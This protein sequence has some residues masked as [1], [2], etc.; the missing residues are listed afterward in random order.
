MKPPIPNRLKFLPTILCLS[1]LAHNADAAI[2]WWDP[3]GTTSV[4]GNGTWDTTTPLWAPTTTTPAGAQAPSANL[5]V[6]NPANAA[7]FCAGPAASTQQGVFTINVESAITFAGLFNGSQ[8][9]GPCDVTITS[10]TGNG[11]LNLASGAQAFS[12]LNSSLGFTRINVPITGAGQIVLESSGQTFLNATNT[13]TGGT[14]LGFSSARWSGIVNFN[15]PYAFGPGPITMVANSGGA[16]VVSG[17]NPITITNSFTTQ[18]T[19]LNLVGNSAGLTFSGNWSLGSSTPN[20]GS[21][22]TGNTVV[23]AGVISGTGGINKSLNNGSAL[24]LSG[25]NTYSGKT[26]ISQGPLKVSSINSVSGGSPS[27]NLGA[28]T[29]AANGTIGIGSGTTAGTLI[30][31][32]V[33]ETTDRIINLGGTTGGATIQN[34]GTGALTFTSDFTAT[35]AGVKTLT[36][37]GSNT[38]NNTIAGKIVNSSA[39]TGVVKA[40]NGTW[41]LN[42]T[43]TYTGGTTIS[44]GT[45]VIGSTGAIVGN[46]TNNAGVL[47]LD[48]RTALTN[49]AALS[50]PSSLPSGAINLNFTGNQVINAIYIDGVLAAP[51][52]WGSPTSGAQNTSPVFTGTGI[53]NVLGAPV[54]VQQPQSIACFEGA[55]NESFTVQVSG[56]P[57][58]TYQWKHQGT[59]IPGAN[60]STYIIPVATMSDAGTYTCAIT[61]NYGGTVSLGAT[62]TVLATNSYVNAILA[63]GPISYWRLGETNGTI[64]HDGVGGN[65]GNY[66]NVALNQPG[67]SQT[68]ADGSVGVPASA[69]QGFVQITNSSPFNFPGVR[70][71]ALESWVN[72]TNVTGVQRI[73]STFA[74]AS[75]RGYA[76][77]INGG[78]VLRFTTSAVQD[79]DQ[80]L[81]TALVPGLWYHLVV[82]SDQSFY[83]FYVNGHEVGT[84]ITITGGGNQGVSQ[85]M[86]FGCNPASYATNFSN[87]YEQL[88][89]RIDEVAIYDFLTA[90]QVLAHYNARYGTLAPPVV[91]APV[92]TPATNYESLSTT[93]QAVAGGQALSYQ[94]FK[95]TTALPGQT[96]D[97]LTI[98]PLHLSDSGAYNVQVSNPVGTNTSTDVTITVLPIPTSASV[99]NLTNG[100][101]LHLPFDSDYADI[102]GHSNNGTNVGATTFVSP[103]A[104]G[105]KAL[106]Y[107]TDTGAGTTNYVTLGVRSDLKFSTN[108]DFTVAFWVRQPAGSTYTNLPFFTDAVGSTSHGGFAFAP[109][110]GTGGGGWMYTIGTVTSPNAATSFPDANL[111]N[112]GNW[113]HL[114]HVASRTA[115]CTTYLDGIQVDSQAITIAGNTD[116]TNPATIGQDPTGAYPVTADADIDD[117]AVWRRALT[118][119]EVSGIY[120]A[121]ATNSVSFAPA[122]ISAPVP[123]ALQLQQN[124]GQWQIIW[125]G[126]GGVLQASG[127]VSGTY[128]NVPSASSPYTI[129]TSSSP[130]M[131]YRLKY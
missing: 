36:L 39:A 15:N 2:Q 69:G 37:Q 14:S 1:I 81:A 47:E 66:I 102:S 34:D 7:G 100:L 67:Y 56:D 108:V 73:F 79:A 25:A 71:F 90:D 21:G 91:S 114:V 3:N 17:T 27:S 78:N 77:G 96:S 51:G 26:T 62:L 131:F 88:N 101:V 57:S 75:P 55:Q 13:Y 105:A 83:H 93:I 63:D 84:G 31:T 110:S 89:G 48:S 130:Q 124:A 46:V 85:P 92:A 44:A 119:L 22:G 87:A 18:S 82:V 30:Y 109:Y 4:G 40:G 70:S 113:H 95:G 76:F 127:D 29:T 126:T 49:N 33:G 64:A 60:D 103:G 54:I 97:T 106:H 80:S 116:N 10:T 65:N 94:W 118:P 43:N 59:N 41:R 42:A 123:V 117:L 104:I 12:T 24:T 52:T 120:L 129:P 23:I 61:N 107:S 9:P 58:F 98:S 19:N 125:T 5:V 122:V 38:G 28:P 121:G 72:F 53:L 74:G 8:N 112:D 68:E 128:T 20:L 6:W 16:L 115:N 35:G 50:F 99:L 11:S 45:L 86:Q 32:G 111:I